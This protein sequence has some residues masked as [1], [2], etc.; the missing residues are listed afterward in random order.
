MEKNHQKFICPK[1]K[2]EVYEMNKVLHNVRCT[3]NNKE[4]DNL[5]I[6]KKKSTQDFQIEELPNENDLIFQ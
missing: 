2:T 1:C 3:D 4:F 6:N 5:S